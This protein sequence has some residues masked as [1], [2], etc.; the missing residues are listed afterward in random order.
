MTPKKTNCIS[1]KKCTNSCV[2]LKKHELDFAKEDRLKELC[3]HCMLCGNC[4]RVCPIQ[5]DGRARMLQHRY[6]H[7][8][9][10]GGKLQGY[11]ALRLEKTNYLFKNY[12][13]AKKRSILFPG[14]NYASLFPKTLNRI[15]QL[16]S[17]HGVGVAYDCCG[18]PIGE[19]GLKKEEEAIVDKLNRRFHDKEIEEI[20]V[21]CPNCAAYLNGKTAVPLVTIYQ[22]LHELGLGTPLTAAS[23]TLPIFLPCPDRG[24]RQLLST[25]LPFLNGE[26]QEIREV[27]CCGLGGVVSAK[28]PSFQNRLAHELKTQREIHRYDDIYV[29]CASCAGSFKR[30]QITKVHHILS[31]ILQTD[32]E[33]DIQHSLWNRMQ[34]LWI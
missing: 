5:I 3:H 19:L 7:V 1:C 14:C 12:R 2:F 11:T 32:E 6:D 34:H 25:A 13:Q 17:P 22:K 10:H 8:E 24:S 21:M 26:I 23:G 30:Q 16:L 31:K 18:K 27:Q 33:A 9:E 29:Y 28:E 20:I 15:V 4:T